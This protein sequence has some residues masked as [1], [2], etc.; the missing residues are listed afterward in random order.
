M[1]DN[2]TNMRKLSRKKQ[3]ITA[4]FSDIACSENWKTCIDW[5]FTIVYR[6][7]LKPHNCFINSR[8]CYSN[9]MSNSTDSISVLLILF[10]NHQWHFRFAFNVQDLVD[11]GCWSDK[12]FVDSI[13][14]VEW[15]SEM[16]AIDNETMQTDSCMIVKKV[17]DR[18]F[19]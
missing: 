4:V 5:L 17:I 1:M 14:F 16:I 13:N 2:P 7:A 15:L 8:R 3:L 10:H 11:T 12:G 6:V 19:L 9:E 18:E